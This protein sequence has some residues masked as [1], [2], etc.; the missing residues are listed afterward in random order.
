MVAE[1][2]AE[3]G[4]DF[5]EGNDERG[6][7]SRLGRVLVRRSQE[8]LAHAPVMCLLVRVS[9]CLKGL[10]ARLCRRISLL[11]TTLGINPP[12]RA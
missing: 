9:V 4:E 1:L 12:L 3:P 7:T 6:V 8:T 10:A 2:Q 11:R 5:A